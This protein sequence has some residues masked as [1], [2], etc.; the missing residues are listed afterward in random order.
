MADSPN[1]D[2]QRRVWND[3]E[4]VE[5]WKRRERGVEPLTAPLLARLALRPGERVLDIGCG[6]GNTTIA[7]AAAVGASGAAVGVDLSAALL[8]LA[9][10]RAVRAGVPQASFVVE[11]AQTGSIPGAPFDVAM[12]RL[13]VMFFS[14][15]VTAFTNIRRHLRRDGRLVFLC[16]QEGEANPSVSPVVVRLFSS[17]GAGSRY[18]QRVFPSGLLSRT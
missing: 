1:N 17:L 10:E 9:R 16:L 6:G 11:D 5:R 13:G 7:A 14:Q 4:F 2:G 15:P 12:S 3:R 8:E 18:S